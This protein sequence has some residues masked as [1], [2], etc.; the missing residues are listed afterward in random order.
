MNT[1][2]LQNALLMATCVL[3]TFSLV[4]GASCTRSE[5][6]SRPEVGH[7]TK[8][9]P[10]QKALG[11]GKL[12]SQKE[13]K[14]VIDDPSL[15]LTFEQIKDV[16]SKAKS[17]AYQI[18]SVK[19]GL[20]PSAKRKLFIA[21][22]ELADRIPVIFSFQVLRDDEK[23]VLVDSGFISER[24]K[25]KW[26]VVD[27]RDPVVGLGALG[28]VPEQV[29]DII[30]THRHWDHVGGLS[31][32][33]KSKIWMPRLEFKTA[34]RKFEAKSP[35]IVNALKSAESEG[36]MKWTKRLQEIMPGIV[37][38]RQGLHTRHFQ[39]VIVKSP[40]GIWVIASDVGGLYENFD[41]PVSSGQTLNPE[42]S[43]QA[44]RHIM[45]LVDNRLDRIVPSH[46]P[47]VFTRFPSVKPGV[48][49]ITKD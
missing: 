38:V 1:R 11:N 30:I 25:R 27:Y 22:G 49:L 28:I 9:I 47:K 46:D 35:V 3:M 23:I 12:K 8:K 45:Q 10:P 5:E 43:V 15:K 33:P 19:V 13:K 2:L 42:A 7:K 14:F 16:V 18:Y 32:F 41:G 44:L 6:T 24:M 20:T 48:V 17:A 39:Y 40:K 26:K 21:R 4:L 37:V 36:R 34:V 29:D 31:L